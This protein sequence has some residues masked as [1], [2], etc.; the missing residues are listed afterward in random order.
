MTGK[1]RDGLKG[2]VLSL[3]DLVDYQAGT[4]ASRMVVNNPAGS[5][6]IFSFDQGEGVSEH[7]APFDSV[8]T[9]L[10]GEAGVWIG[11]TTHAMTA[12]Q[13]IV[14]PANVPHA[15]SATTPFK[16]ALVMIRGE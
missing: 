15:F 3:A 13:T 1:A 11:G 12:D 7:T 2:R 16:M 9:I 8:V 4:V 10:D 5:I 6:T 14:V